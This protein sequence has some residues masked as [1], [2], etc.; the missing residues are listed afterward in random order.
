[1]TS[2]IYLLAEAGTRF[3]RDKTGRRVVSVA[4]GT[5]PIFRTPETGTGCNID[6]MSPLSND[7]SHVYRLQIR[8]TKVYNIVVTK[9]EWD[10]ADAIVTRFMNPNQAKLMMDSIQ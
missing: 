9:H 3:G 8:T 4:Y 10:M 7:P 2:P 6:F 1:M 5:F